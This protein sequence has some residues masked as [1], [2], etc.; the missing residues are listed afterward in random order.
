ME[1]KVIIYITLALFLALGF[2]FFLYLHRKGNLRPKDYILF[3]FRT[4]SLFLVL[5]ILINPRLASTSYTIVKPNL[6]VLTD[7]SQSLR[8]LN[9]EDIIQNILQELKSDKRLTSKFDLNII[10][11]GNEL[12]LMEELDYNSG[13]TNIYDALEETEKLF[14]DKPSAVVLLSDG[15]QSFGRE[16]KYYTSGIGLKLFPVVLG[17]TTSYK[18]LSIERLNSNPYAFLNNKFPLEIF[19]S[20]AGD[21]NVES[22]V[23]IHSSGKELYREK[24]EF[25]PGERSHIL[26]TEILASKLGVNNFEVEIT[27]IKDEKNTLNNVQK[28]AVEIIDERTSVLILSSMIHP[29]LGAFKKAI[30]SN[31]QR[32]VTIMETDDI[33][34]QLKD[35]QLVIMYQVN[36]S[37]NEFFK[38][39]KAENISFLVVTGSE[40]D[41][42][43]L[44]SLELGI[45]K[46]SINQPQEIFP[47][48]NTNFSSFQFEDIGFDDFPPLIDKF[49]ELEYRESD[50][51]MMLLQEL[52]GLNTGAPLLAVSHNAPKFGF[53]LGENIWRWRAKSFLDNKSFK[54]FDDFFGKLIQNLSSS[55]RRDRLNLEY[56]KFFY[57]NQNVIINAQFFDENYRFDGGKS[58]DINLTNMDSNTSYTSNLVFKNNFYQFN[59]GDLPIGNYSFSVKVSGEN[60]TKNGNFEIIDYNPEQ[61]FVSAN[62][63]G[64]Q[65]LAQSNNSEVFFPN[66][67]SFLKNRLASDESLK[68][69]QKSHQKIVPLIDWY[70]LLFILILV[71]A[72]EWFYR[73]YLGLI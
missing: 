69:V 12:E 9:Q 40:T 13:Q 39:L 22:L 3:G 26:R 10:R 29:D 62:F 44:N 41:W 2:S 14:A 61:Q 4:A 51:D 19:L 42:N 1:I 60:L 48:Y 56:D 27:P 28:F 58:L 33:N 20:Y 73:K 66:Q 55:K 49:G 31:Q 54:E 52:Q 35:Y 64:M 32:S 50:L 24:L 53:L 5:L 7:N 47:V 8:F 72:A 25:S 11:F 23:K 57:A 38:Q 34:F 65:S 45:E 17:D 6:V 67:L 46:N 15:N 68:P 43:Y 21:E 59:G 16:Y 70:Y 63:T 30:E 18:D 71:L 36:R 37:F